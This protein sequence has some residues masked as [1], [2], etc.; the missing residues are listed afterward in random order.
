MQVIFIKSIPAVLLSI[1]LSM[2]LPTNKTDEVRKFSLHVKVNLED[3]FYLFQI[4]GWERFRDRNISH[5]VNND[6][7]ILISP[8]SKGEK[9]KNQ[10]ILSM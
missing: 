5:Y 1:H 2:S 8:E 7:K 3:D 9:R 10:T 6:T 4:R